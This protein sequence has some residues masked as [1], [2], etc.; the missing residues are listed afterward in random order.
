V[1][2]TGSG[3]DRP[4]VEAIRSKVRAA[5]SL[6]GRTS[7][8]ELAAVI[9][10]LDVLVSV[11]SGPAHLAAAVRT[12]LVVLWGPAI[13]EQVRP[14]STAS[15]VALLRN[16][17]PC[18]PCYDTPLMKTCPRNVCM[19]SISPREVLDRVDRLLDRAS[20]GPTRASTP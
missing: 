11:D 7:P 2:F 4:D 12:P 16:P 3:E 9:E 18:A 20:G 14:L 17:P 10:A 15:E 6:A 19:E 8:R 5:T 1:I 13:L